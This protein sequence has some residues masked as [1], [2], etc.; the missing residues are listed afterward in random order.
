MKRSSSL[1]SVFSIFYLLLA[2]CA[3]INQ[4]QKSGKGRV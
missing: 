4:L 1:S 2:I 3:I